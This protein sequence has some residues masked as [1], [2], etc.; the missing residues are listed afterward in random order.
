M[1]CI[2]RW[3]FAKGMPSGALTYWGS[4]A[5][6]TKLVLRPKIRVGPSPADDGHP[7]FLFRGI[8]LHP[9]ADTVEPGSIA[10]RNWLAQAAV[11]R[12]AVIS[13]SEELSE[14]AWILDGYQVERGKEE[15]PY[16]RPDLTPVDVE[17]LHQPRQHDPQQVARLLASRHHLLQAGLSTGPSLSR[18]EVRNFEGV[19]DRLPAGS[20]TERVACLLMAITARNLLRG[21]DLYR[22]LGHAMNYSFDLLKDLERKTPLLPVLNGSFLVGPSVEPHEDDVVQDLCAALLAVHRQG[23][24]TWPL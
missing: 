13:R 15:G 5:R 19:L 7:P 12:F 17:D 3:P 23:E 9:D 24:A 20:P 18:A 1:T 10:E 2:D 21:L 22:S 14:D 11:L 4:P 16:L 8:F 6:A